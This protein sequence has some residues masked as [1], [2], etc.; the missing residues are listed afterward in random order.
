VKVRHALELWNGLEPERKL[1][2]GQDVK[3]RTREERLDGLRWHLHQCAH[4]AAHPG[5]GWS[6]DEALLMLSTLSAMLALRRP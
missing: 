2:A 5:G 3:G 1:L 4:L 6:R